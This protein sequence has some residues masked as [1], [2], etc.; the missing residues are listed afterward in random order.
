MCFLLPIAGCFTVMGERP[1]TLYNNLVEIE[2]TARRVKEDVLST[3]PLF[4]F[5]DAKLKTMGVTDLTD[6]LHRMPG[7]NIRDY[8]GAGGMKTVSSRCSPRLSP[9]RPTRGPT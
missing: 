8:G 7:L 3:A 4:R 6:A 2:V 1:D 9:P 5:D